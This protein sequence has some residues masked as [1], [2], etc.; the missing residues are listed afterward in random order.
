M[1]KR[2]RKNPKMKI[3]Y[4]MLLVLA[5]ILLFASGCFVGMEIRDNNRNVSQSQEVNGI[6]NNEQENIVQKLPTTKVQT[7]L[8]GMDISD[9]VYQMMFV[10]P[11]AITKVERAVRAGES[12][13]AALEEYPVGGI[14]YFAQNFQDRDQTK[15][16]I[17]NS[18]TYSK[19]PLFIGVDEEGGSVTRLGSNS[20]MGVAEHPSMREI[21]DTKDPQKAYDTGKVMGNDLKG[22]GF[23]VN[24]APVADVLTNSN[25]TAIGNRSFGT[26]PDNVSIMVKNI[27]MG[28]EENGVS[29][30]VK[31]F[32]GHGSTKTDSHQGYTENI[33]TMAELEEIELKPFKAG[34]EAGTDFIMVSHMTLVNATKEKVP[35]SVSKEI[36]TDLLKGQLN[37][38]GIVITDSFSMS[39]ITDNY[40]TGQAVVKAIN[41]GA[42][43][44]LMPQDIDSAHSAVVSALESGEIPEERIRESV[45]KILMLKE[46]K[47]ML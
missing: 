3:V 25:N 10:T 31:H 2:K 18:Q 46:E 24:F 45:L 14:V 22:L 4:A 43:M 37:Y 47:G 35:C 38:N 19:I 11:E 27:V 20:N 42:D 13:K 44:I 40:T 1:S 28:L 30:G 9:M 16:M 12:T 26:E 34:I 32:P 23:N 36:M 39:A 41:A 7:I 5:G 33:R 8:D 17:A 29:A 6:K 15:Q 21:G